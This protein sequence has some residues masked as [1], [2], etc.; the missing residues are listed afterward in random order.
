MERPAFYTFDTLGGICFRVRVTGVSIVTSPTGALL[1][2]RCV[3]LPG[4]RKC[5]GLLL[6]I[7]RRLNQRGLA[8]RHTLGGTAPV[9]VDDIRTELVSDSADHAHG[10]VRARDFGRGR[11]LGAVWLHARVSRLTGLRRCAHHTGSLT[12]IICLYECC[13]LLL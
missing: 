6:R 5:L 11:R 3:Y 1:M 10:L 9:G 7:D 13:E 8:I 4:A 2:A 12:A